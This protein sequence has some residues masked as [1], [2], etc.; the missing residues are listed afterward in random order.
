MRVFRRV[1]RDPCR[2]AAH[3]QSL[4]ISKAESTKRAFAQFT[5]SS[6]H[7]HYY[8]FLTLFSTPHPP[9]PSPHTP[10]PGPPPPP[11]SHTP[12]HPRPAPRPLP[13]WSTCRGPW[14]A[15]P[16]IPMR[17]SRWSCRS[18]P[19]ISVS[20]PHR[21][22][23]GGEGRRI[24]GKIILMMMMMMVVLMLPEGGKGEGRENSLP[25]PP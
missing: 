6:Y 14:P 17:A 10:P 21:Q 22:R 11:P 19:A 7:S 3:P 5:S 18:W 24:I 16:T 4:F 1:E 20:G 8:P 9:S 13:S 15:R 12:A 2:T 23:G 25:L